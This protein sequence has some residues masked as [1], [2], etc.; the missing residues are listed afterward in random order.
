MTNKPSH[1]YCNIAA[2]RFT[3]LPLPAR[4]LKQQWLP[5]LI[6]W[7]LKG[8]ILLSD[9][10]GININLAGLQTGIDAFIA[11]CQNTPGLNDLPFKLS[12]SS[13][14]PFSKTIIKVKPQIIPLN[15]PYNPIA[16][17]GNAID[18]QTLKQWL[19]EGKDFT[20]LDARNDYE[21]E[22]GKFTQAVDCHIE[23][24]RD[25][26]DMT[27]VMPD[28]VK[29]KPLVTYCTGG[30][31][32]EKVALMLAQQGFQEVYQLDGGILKYFEDCGDAHYQG[33]CY[34]FDDRV[35]VKPD[36]SEAN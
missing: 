13:F 15:N 33:N 19:D 34:V 26:E 22:H 35:A 28:E 17:R 36:L 32:C 2:Y 6:A 23:N 29:Q 14:I 30:I 8:T 7:E 31:R 3:K 21:I 4:E 16:H 10:E 18:A 20:L 5:K 11:L 12:Y 1:Q 25:M 27:A 24:F 9:N